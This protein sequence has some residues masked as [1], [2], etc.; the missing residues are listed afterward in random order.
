MVNYSPICFLLFAL[1]FY[2]HFNRAFD[3]AENSPIGVQDRANLLARADACVLRYLQKETVDMKIRLMPHILKRCALTEYFPLEK[4]GN[5]LNGSSIYSFF[6]LFQH[7]HLRKCNSFLFFG[8][9]SYDMSAEIEIME[10][11]DFE[12]LK[13][14]YLVVDRRKNLYRVG[15][16]VVP[17]IYRCFTAEKL[18]TAT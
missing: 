4:F 17:R 8:T 16:L 5:R 6:P 15:F 1:F 9:S 12:M 14:N 18:Y 10:N 11:V 7:S 13:C 2:S 3:D